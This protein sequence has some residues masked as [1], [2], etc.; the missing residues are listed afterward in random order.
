MADNT[1]WSIVRNRL[2]YNHKMIN[3]PTDQAE[4]TLVPSDSST[5]ILETPIFLSHS[6][7]DDVVPITNGKNSLTLEKLGMVVSWKQ[8]KDGG[9]WVNE[10]QGV[11]DIVVFIRDVVESGSTKK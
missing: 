7:D 6:R 10:P 2:H 11:D 9:H 8:Y 4:T 5:F 3:T 1:V